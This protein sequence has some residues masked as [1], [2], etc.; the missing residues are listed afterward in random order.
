M[1]FRVVCSC[2]LLCFYP[3]NQNDNDEN[4]LQIFTVIWPYISTAS[5][6]RISHFILYL[7]LLYIIVRLLSNIIVSGPDVLF[8][9]LRRDEILD[10]DDD[11]DDVSHH[12]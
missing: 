11:D 5:V 9:D 3:L 12:I 2:V 4:D 1:W 10:D 7:A 8:Q 6:H